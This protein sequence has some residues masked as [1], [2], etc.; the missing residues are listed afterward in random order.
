MASNDTQVI[1]INDK[2]LYSLSQLSTVFGPARET[3]SKRLKD[4]KVSARGERASHKVYHIGD[5]ARA[6]LDGEQRTFDQVDDPD[7]LPPK[8]R[9]DWYRSE[10]EKQKFFLASD[11]AVLV[12]DAAA[13]MAGIVKICVR[14]L[15]TIPDILEMKCGLSPAEIQLVEDE[16]DAARRSLAEKL[17]E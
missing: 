11:Q 9:L 2:Y 14:T 13:E 16:C 4:G 1:D 5:A 12:E 8:A 3:I 17:A 6:I 10:T 15:D 7:S